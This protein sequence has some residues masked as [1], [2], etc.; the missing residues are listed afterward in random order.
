LNFKGFID[1]STS[2]IGAIVLLIVA[3]AGGSVLI[4][5]VLDERGDEDDDED[6]L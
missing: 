2:G 6:R 1:F 3:N 5:Q 4:R